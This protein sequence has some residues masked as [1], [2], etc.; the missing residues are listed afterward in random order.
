VLEKVNQ[1]TQSRWSDIEFQKRLNESGFEPML[2]LGP[3]QAALYLSEEIARWAPLVQAI[4]IQT[5][6]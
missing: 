1:V 2:G 3:D 4:G 6:P 5:Q